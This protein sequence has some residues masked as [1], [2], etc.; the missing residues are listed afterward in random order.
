MCKLSHIQL[1]A[2]PWAVCSLPV[3]SAHRTFQGRNT[4]MGCHFSSSR[5]SSPSRDLTCI[6]YISCIGKQILYH[7]LHLGSQ[8]I[9]TL[10]ERVGGLRLWM[11]E[12]VQASM[13]AF[14]L[15]YWDGFGHLAVKDLVSDESQWHH[16]N[17]CVSSGKLHNC[18]VPQV[19]HIAKWGYFQVWS[20]RR[21]IKWDCASSSS[22]DGHRI[23]VK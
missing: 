10:H 3:C 22:R 8:E 19:P 18:S 1:F 15:L 12:C 2:A 4:E 21:S 20:Y 7:L 17:S 6:S 14:M 16:F 13:N 9:K 11:N 23:N 5:G